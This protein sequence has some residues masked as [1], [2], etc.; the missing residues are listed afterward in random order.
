MFQWFDCQLS[1]TKHTYCETHSQS[2]PVHYDRFWKML[3]LSMKFWQKTVNSKLNIS[4][5]RL[6]TV[7]NQCH[8]YFICVFLLRIIK[9][10]FRYCF[11]SVVFHLRTFKNHLYQSMWNTSSG[12]M[13]FPIRVAE[14]L[15]LFFH[16]KSHAVIQIEQDNLFN[17]YL[18]R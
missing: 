16:L 4:W 5:A 10:L 2:H 6:A 3:F 13:C 18:T 11:F 17:L 1:W 7:K 8:C 9:N 15:K 14:W 12:W